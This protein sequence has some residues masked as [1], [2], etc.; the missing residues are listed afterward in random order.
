MSLSIAANSNTA[1]ILAKGLLD[2]QQKQNQLTLGLLEVAATQKLIN[3]QQQTAL[4]AVALMTG[5]GTKLD[6]TV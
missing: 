2:S 4:L 3:Q 5:V 6:I 1:G